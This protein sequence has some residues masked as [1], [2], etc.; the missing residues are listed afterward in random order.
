MS[1]GRLA[2]YLAT[3]VATAALLAGGTAASRGF[4]HSPT[5]PRARAAAILTHEFGARLGVCFL[6]I[7]KRETGGTY[8]PRAANYADHHSDGS[9]GS[10]GLLQIGAI[11]RSHGE[12]IAAFMR[13]MFVPEANARVGHALYRRSGLRP[14]GGYC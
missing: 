1:A 5:P 10:F 3:A 14:W 9:Y 8:N 12:T 4:P 2:L 6:S 7:A 11:H 13:R